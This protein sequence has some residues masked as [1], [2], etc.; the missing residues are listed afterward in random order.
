[1]TDVEI[2]LAIARLEYPDDEAYE[3]GDQCWVEFDF[4][5]ETIYPDY[6]KNWSDIGPV[7]EREKL[8]LGCNDTYR[9]YFA[10]DGY[11]NFTAFAETPTKAAALWYLKMKESE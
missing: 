6:C 8:T 2:N 11:G 7:I 4:Y 5:N 3:N 10:H 1:M 9:A